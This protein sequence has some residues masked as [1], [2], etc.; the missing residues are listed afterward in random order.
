MI[1]AFNDATH[2]WESHDD[3]QFADRR[4][5]RL[6]FF[7]KGLHHMN[8]AAAGKCRQLISHPSQQIIGEAFAQ[9]IEALLEDK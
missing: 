9:E 7:G 4:A 1:Q 5:E 8:A 6:F 2:A 3:W